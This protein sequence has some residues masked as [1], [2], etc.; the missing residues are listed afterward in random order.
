MWA[1][2]RGWQGPGVVEVTDSRPTY[3]DPPVS[4]PI[5]GKRC[6]WAPMRMEW[7]FLPEVGIDDATVTLDLDPQVPSVL[8]IQVTPRCTLRCCY[9]THFFNPGQATTDISNEEI[10]VLRGEIAR[11]P[12]HGVVI[13]SGGEP[14]MRPD[15]V[16]RLAEDSP[17]P[18]AVYTNGTLLTPSLV[19]RLRE[20]RILPVVSVD[21]PPEVT[22]LRRSNPESP[23][24]TQAIF[25][26]LSLLAAAGVPYAIAMVLGGHNIERIDEHVD[27]LYRE[28]EP[29]TIGVSIPHFAATG[30]RE[31]LTPESVAE[32]FMRLFGLALH[33]GIYID[34]IARRLTPF[35]EG[36]PRLRDCSACGD[37]KV[38]FP[39]G[40][41][42][43]C[44][45]NT[46]PDVGALSWARYLPVLTPACQGCIGIG[47][48]GGGC[49]FDGIRFHGYGKF[50]ARL[51]AT[52]RAVTVAILRTC[53]TRPEL[54]TTNRAALRELFGPLVFR[55]A[56]RR[57]SVG[58]TLSNLELR[59]T[60][61]RPEAGRSDLIRTS[62]SPTPAGPGREP[63]G[64]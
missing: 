16:F 47:L 35:V 12:S 48:C 20:T 39:G 4:I 59:G 27:H 19:A 56:E 29:T 52:V 32:A 9:C 7:S 46:G 41:W 60:T 17:V 57:F 25:R 54:Q 13:L 45:N 61:D 58:H 28:Y 64:A 26:G 5:N 38:Y 49:V 53:A 31:A 1:R 22:A 8:Q 14:F 43:N 30:L 37:K 10:E 3:R 36:R 51:C 33:K 18:V 42:K 24:A 21:G 50:D 44:A 6:A 15:A 23:R 2:R 34:Q 11:L 55:P 62:S 63:S 40:T